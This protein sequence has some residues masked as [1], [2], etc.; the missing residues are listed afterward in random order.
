MKYLAA[1]AL[2]RIVS[3]DGSVVVGNSWTT[4][5]TSGIRPFIWDATNGMQSLDV[6]LTS[7]GLD[8]TGWSL[9][10]ASGI[11]ADGPTI[12]GSG[13]NPAGNQEAHRAY[14]GPLPDPPGPPPVPAMSPIARGLVALLL[15][16]TC[17]AALRA[18]GRRSRRSGA[19]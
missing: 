6:V 4:S 12:V 10:S 13:I 3:A 18:R 2:E 14:L 16:A 17:S 9:R 15:A 19:G 11:S 8:L 7:L 5:G 1:G